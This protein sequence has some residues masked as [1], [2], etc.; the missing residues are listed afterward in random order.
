PRRLLSREALAEV[1]RY[2]SGKVFRSR[3]RV[4]VKLAEAPSR[5]Q[6]IFEYAFESNGAEDYLTLAKEVGAQRAAAA[7]PKPA[8]PVP[9]AS[10]RRQAPPP[11]PARAP[12]AAPVPIRRLTPLAPAAD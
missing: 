6:T 9:A 2:F 3:I 1:E 10:K 5:G 4:N 7:P 8:A 12:K 11:K